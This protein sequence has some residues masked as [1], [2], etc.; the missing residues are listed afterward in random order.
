MLMY[1]CR[2]LEKFPLYLEFTSETEIKLDEV[3]KFLGE[4]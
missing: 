1:F 2:F 3:A 4:N